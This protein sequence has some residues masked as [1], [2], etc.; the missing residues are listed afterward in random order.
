MSFEITIPRLGWSMEEGIFAGWMKKDGDVVR[1]GDALFELE[2]EKALQEIEALDDG[3]LRIPA[4]GP[5]PGTVL[6]VGAVIGYLL[7]DGESLPKAPSGSNETST[8]SEINDVTN[9]KPVASNNQGT[10]VGVAASPSVRRLARELGVPLSDVTASGSGDRVTEEDV[11]SAATRTTDRNMAMSTSSSGADIVATPRA[12]RAAKQA[13]VDMTQLQGTG[14][15]GRIRERD[16]VNAAKTQ[17]PGSAGSG[18][19]RIVLSGRRKVIAERL[20]ESQRQVVP[21]TLTSQADAANLVSLREQFKAAGESMVPAFHDIISKLVAGCLRQERRLAGRWDGDAI[22]LP[23]DDEIHIGI[24]VDT[25]EGLIVPVLRNV[26]N[27]PLLSL[28]AESSR[29]I[30][31]ARDGRLSGA[32][33]QDAVFTITNLGGFSIDAFTPVINLPETAILG[34]GAIRKQAVVVDDDRI[35]VRP[36][37]TLSLTFDHRAIDGAP[38][39]RFLQSVV[40]AIENPAA[41][42]LMA[43]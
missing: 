27:E 22:V 18:R 28:V 33:M 17:V 20:A 36:M 41:R 26:V 15:N 16:V 11:R 2:G 35:E 12:R 37:M 34:L 24:A 23:G 4:D 19:Q 13:G 32:D 21:V 10:N 8:A 42:L 25:L 6:K 43:D 29:I 5:Q 31:R 3:M 40:A 1:R 30:R 38:A 9:T 39:A 14:R 7:A